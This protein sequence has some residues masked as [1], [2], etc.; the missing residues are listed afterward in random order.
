[1]TA[2]QIKTPL[3][4]PK[5][6]AIID[7]DSRFVSP[8]YTR[9]YPLVIARGEGAVVEDVDGNLFLDC[10]AGIAVNST[11]VSHPEVVKAISEQAA[12]FIHMS[13]TDFYYEPQVRLA[14]EL[15]S[16]VPIDG[17]VRTFFGNSGTEATE[18]ALKL[19]RYHTKR[20][21]IIA[22]LGSFHGRSLG[23]LALTSS[24][25]VQ[26]RGFGPFMP[27]VYHAPYPDVY[28]FNGSPDACA[29]ASLTVI[30]E[31][32]LVHLIAPDEVA[33][34]V[35]EPIQGEGGYIVPPAS[36][37]QGLREIASQH[38]IMLVV[39]EVQS[40][41]G[42]TGRMFASEHFALKADIVNIAKGIASGLPLGVTCARSAV[43][44]WP[45]GAHASTF[46]GN[47]VACAAALTTIRLLR[48]HYV[49]NAAMVGEH[50]MSGL[51]ELQ[52]K[53]A[54]VGDVRGKGLMI[55][56]ELVRDR[57][58]KARAVE[59]RNALVQAMFRRGV[60][61]LGAGRNAIRFAPPLVLTKDQA[62]AVL[63]V[64]DEALTEV[65]RE[66]AVAA[67]ASNGTA[68]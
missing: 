47:P 17:D 61:I 12:K 32:I 6:K 44:S 15:A 42:R 34:I 28:R 11:G 65:T 59:E 1:M 16:V 45:P 26:R 29:E 2:P 25:S 21:G 13:G 10:A 41:M 48:E 8:S 33:A 19:S 46:G 4:G 55:G 66:H 5:A 20:S 39:D 7:K 62:D 38:G 27:G 37:L 68:S 60:L 63:G 22:F 36:F 52:Q 35:V 49:K 53:H 43:M 40:G 64:F 58:T 50:L 14:E 18:A 24:K 67:S 3:P 30:R 51:R 56:V 57:T 54:L 31:Q 9:D 23:S